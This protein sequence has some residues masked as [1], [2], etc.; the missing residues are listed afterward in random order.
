MRI[1]KLSELTGVS[2]RSLRYYGET[3]LLSVRRGSGGHRIYDPADVAQVRFIQAL[4]AVGFSTRD[5]GEIKRHRHEEPHQSESRTTAMLL[6]QS[7][8]MDGC[9]DK[10]MK[11]R[12]QL[13]S[14]IAEAQ[15]RDLGAS[16]RGAPLPRY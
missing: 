7:D 10:L 12:S 11:A 1:G 2:V 6:E 5:I 8:V 14:L 15:A 4:L 16:P 13:N 3:G 9:I